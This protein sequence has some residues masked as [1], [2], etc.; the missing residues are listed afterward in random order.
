LSSFSFSFCSC[1]SYSADNPPHYSNPKPLFECC[2]FSR[3]FFEAFE[4]RDFFEAIDFTDFTDFS[5]LLTAE[6]HFE[7]RPSLM[8]D[9]ETAFYRNTAFLALFF[10][11]LG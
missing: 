9:S 7:F 2:S 4:L 1:L 11:A 3:E 10:G 6:L 8:F 5:D